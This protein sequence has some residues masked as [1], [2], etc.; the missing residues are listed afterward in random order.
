MNMF[1]MCRR[2]LIEDT[3]GLA[4]QFRKNIE[5]TSA[6]KVQDLEFYIEGSC[7]HDCKSESPEFS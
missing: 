2:W 3:K 1:C 4:T 5:K 7:L 6:V